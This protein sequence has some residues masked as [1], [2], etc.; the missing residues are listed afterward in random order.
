MFMINLLDSN[1]FQKLFVCFIICAGASVANAQSYCS[2]SPKDDD[3]WANLEQRD[4]NFL[5][6]AYFADRNCFLGF[7]ESDVNVN[8]QDSDGNTAL[9]LLAM[10]GGDI[11]FSLMKTLIDNPNTNLAVVNHEGLSVFDVA[12]VSVVEFI[13]NMINEKT[14]SF[15]DNV[16]SGNV[17]EVVTALRLGVDPNMRRKGENSNTALMT[18]I[19]NR[20][21]N[22]LEAILDAPSLDVNFKIENETTALMKSAG[23]NDNFPE[24]RLLVNKRGSD[25]DINAKDLNDRTALMHAVLAGDSSTVSL[26]LNEFKETID[27]QIKAV[28]GETALLMAKRLEN[29]EVVQRLKPGISNDLHNAIKRGDVETVSSILAQIMYAN[30]GDLDTS[31]ILNMK[32]ESKIANTPLMNAISGEHGNNN[33]GRMVHLI[34]SA[35]GVDLNATNNKGQTFLML[36]AQEGGL[37]NFSIQYY[38]NNY[39]ALEVNMQDNDGNTAL[40][41]A[42][43]ANN[44][45]VAQTLLSSDRVQIGLRN[46][47]TQTALEIA[48][49]LGNEEVSNLLSDVLAVYKDEFFKAAELCNLDNLRLYRAEINPNTRNEY[50][51]TALIIAARSGCRNVVSELL[52]YV[53]IDANAKS[54]DGTTALTAAIVDRRVRAANELLNNAEVGVNVYGRDGKTALMWAVIVG[55][56]ILVEQLITDHGADFS[57]RDKLENQTAFEHAVS[58]GQVRVVERFLSIDTFEPA[59]NANLAIEI[60]KNKGHDRIVTILEDWQDSQITFLMRMCFWCKKK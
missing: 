28:S 45:P 29:T 42:A 24:T 8:V 17:E 50:G 18:A 49:S 16:E 60:A 10:R 52:S 19:E 33:R 27:T 23:M 48:K 39:G 32:E 40:M 56:D 1:F 57:L 13:A 51:E 25:I 36:V 44:F 6:A 47:E 14:D 2:V 59:D 53:H 34:A 37:S 21:I 26:L 54:D 4:A 55:N 15:L 22:M 9:I 58:V 43:R 35:P 11:A 20:D 30:E 12:D 41:Y 3:P 38:E 7:L 46:N 31:D 5:R